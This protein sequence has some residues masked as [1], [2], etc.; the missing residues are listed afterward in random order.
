M[1]QAIAEEAET[2]TI[3]MFET[4]VDTINFEEAKD[5]LKDTNKVVLRVSDFGVANPE[6]LM[7]SDGF[8]DKSQVTTEQAENER[9]SQLEKEITSSSTASEAID[10]INTFN[11]F[12]ITDNISDPIFENSAEVDAQ[13]NSAY[14]DSIRKL[15]FTDPEDKDNPI[16]SS[17]EAAGMDLN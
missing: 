13:I 7:S 6:V 4:P 16:L 9:L 12:E 8:V 1:S 3:S 17:E 2:T 14:E 10:I 11:Q 5:N 15:K